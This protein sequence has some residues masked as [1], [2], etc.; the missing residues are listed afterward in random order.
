MNR[1]SIGMAL[2]AAALTGAAWSA[3]LRTEHT[4]QL[5]PDETRPAATLDDADFLVGSWSGTA[6]GET[7]EAV[8]N[9][10]SAGTM[11]GLFKLY[12]DDGIA[13]YEILLLSVEEGTL[14]LKVK[15]FNADFSA[16]EDKP[17]YVNFRLIKKDKDA[18]HFGGLS[19]YKRGDDGIDGYIVM[20]RGEDF[21]EHHLKYERQ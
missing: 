17:D 19:F 5:A 14:S 4:Y 13:F 2:I 15:H 16:W 18:L 8:W 6:F 10:P 9:A 11:I 21:Q 12:G 3:E 20:R 1:I 7:F